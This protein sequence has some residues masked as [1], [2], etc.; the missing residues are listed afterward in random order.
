MAER[1]AK[2]GDNWAQRY[3]YMRFHL[4]TSFC[5]L[6]YLPYDE[7]LRGSHFLT[8]DELASQV[9]KC[10][11]TFNLNMVTSAQIQ[12]TQYDSLTMDWTIKFKTPAGQCT[13]VAKHLVLATGIGSQRLNLPRVADNHL[14]Q[15]ISLHSAWYKNAKELANKGARVSHSLIRVNKTKVDK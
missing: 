8:K 6:P 11:E 10:V 2:P 7:K 4:P 12:S 3:D 14:Y 9:N 15:E 1:R 13:A 5:D